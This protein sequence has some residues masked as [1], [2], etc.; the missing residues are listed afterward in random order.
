[1]PPKIFINHYI[2]AEANIVLPQIPTGFTFLRKRGASSILDFYCEKQKKSIE[3][4][5]A[6]AVPNALP[7]Y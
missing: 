5:K 2:S 1:L 6:F 3:K 4:S 7:V